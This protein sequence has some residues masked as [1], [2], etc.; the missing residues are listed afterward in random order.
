MKNERKSRAFNPRYESP[1]QLELEGFE[2][3]FSKTLNPHNRWVVLAKLIPWDD[4][5]S[6]LRRQFSNSAAGRKPL[7]P[8][9]VIGSL[10]IKHML[11]LDDRETVS[12]ISENM[13][14][15]YFLGYSSF[16]DEEPFDASLFVDFRKALGIETINTIN[17]KIVR[18]KTRLEEKNK[19]QPTSEPSVLPAVEGSSEETPQ[20]P[21]PS[22]K[23]RVLFDA[24]ACPQDIAYPTDLNLLSDAREKAE[25]LIDHIY[26]KDLHGE[27]PRTYRREARKY[28]LQT[29][30]K[31]NKTKREIRKSVGKQLRYLKRDI[32]ILHHLLDSYQRLPFDRHQLK[33]FYVIQ[34]LYDQ[35]KEMS[36]KFIGFPIG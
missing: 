4:I 7:N 19:E 30:Q 23:G 2:S 11:N 31:K 21:T 26:N 16:I 3:P 33:Y 18:L 22:H 12:Q 25:E 24:T 29:A 20:E 34:T 9:I 15:Q 27:K 6:P 5:C 10:I 32:G 17:E 8:R 36:T 1:R 13:Y 35:Q 28:Y 14:M